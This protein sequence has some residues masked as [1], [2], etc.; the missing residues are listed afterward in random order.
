VLQCPASG[1]TCL[2]RDQTEAVRKIY[3]GP[4]TSS[5]EVL[6][7]GLTVGSESTWSRLWDVSTVAPTSGGSWL[8]TYRFMVFENP[9]W[10]P[11]TLDFD[12]DPQFAQ[13][14]LGATLSADD[15]DLAAFANRGGKLIVYHGWA[16]HMVPAESSTDYH[17]AVTARLGSRSV[18]TFFRL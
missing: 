9:H 4:H 1:P 3:S 5:G 16:D 8:G 13:R 12:R 7:R 11:V 17:A 14:K 10:D 18:A 2:S 6:G 15:S